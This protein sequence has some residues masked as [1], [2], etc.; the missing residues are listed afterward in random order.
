MEGS[1]RGLGGITVNKNRLA[2]E[3]WEWLKPLLELCGL[4]EEEI[5]RHQY[6][7]TTALIHGYKHGK[8][9]K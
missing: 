7:Y 3:H 9:D 4:S 8:E 5:K 6:L 1:K 2:Q